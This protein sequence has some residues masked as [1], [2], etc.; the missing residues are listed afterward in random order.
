MIRWPVIGELE[1]VAA[2]TAT[3]MTGVPVIHA[4]EAWSR[5]LGLACTALTDTER[6]LEFRMMRAHKE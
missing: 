2:T 4:F 6:I 1:M 3:H 5:V